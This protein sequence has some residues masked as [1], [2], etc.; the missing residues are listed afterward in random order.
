MSSPSSSASFINQEGFEEETLTTPRSS[1]ILNPVLEAPKLKRS[2]TQ[3]SRALL[4]EPLERK[5]EEDPLEL[6]PPTSPKKRRTRRPK[7]SSEEE[8]EPEEAPNKKQK[9]KRRITPSA[10]EPDS[11]SGNLENAPSLE[12]KFPEED[13][14]FAE[15]LKD[16]KQISKDE[17]MQLPSGTHIVY[18]RNGYEEAPRKSV[19]C[20]LQEVLS[21]DVRSVRPYKPFGK[22]T[23]WE[24]KTHPTMNYY[25]SLRKRS[26]VQGSSRA[27]KMVKAARSKKP[28][29]SE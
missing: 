28:K 15:K 6:P 23:Q 18:T 21:E 2:K 19:Y 8:V 22:V 9:T 10:A 7:M 12:I 26:A 16:F 27:N 14:P 4:E 1:P 20:V 29:K 11:K 17:L 25:L 3:G 24:L 13:R 5:L